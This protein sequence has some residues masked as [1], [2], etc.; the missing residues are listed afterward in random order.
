[1]EDFEKKHIRTDLDDRTLHVGKKI[2]EAEME[3]VPYIVVVGEKEEK[4]SKLNVRIRELKEQKEMTKDEIV[5]YI[6]HKTKD[7]PF[8]PLSLPKLLSKRPVFVG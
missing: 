4:G 6:H 1:M 2:R 5:S 7:M 3:W 8:K